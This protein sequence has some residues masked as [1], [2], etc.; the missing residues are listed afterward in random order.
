M[1]VVIV[2]MIVSFSIVF[3]TGYVTLI[4]QR[5]EKGREDAPKWGA[6]FVMIWLAS[7]YFWF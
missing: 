5:P 1:G 3:G 6:F 4:L 2:A 7:R